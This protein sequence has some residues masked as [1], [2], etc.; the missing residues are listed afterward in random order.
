MRSKTI[1]I[2][3]DDPVFT[4]ILSYRLEKYQFCC[5]S[6]HTATDALV[7]LAHQS[8]PDIVLLDYS[9]GPNEQSGVDLCRQIKYMMPGVPLV[10]LTGNDTTQT[11]VSCLDAGADQYVLKPYVLEELLARIRAVGRVYE[12][13]DDIGRGGDYEDFKLNIFEQT[14]TTP[15]GTARLTEKEM[16]FAE[17]MLKSL[18]SPLSREYLYSVIYEREFDSL[19]R[20][21]DMLAVRFRKKL[22]GITKH[23]SIK[24]VRGEGYIMYCRPP[25]T[26]NNSLDSHD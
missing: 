3:D 22:S 16:A 21:L 8:P 19:S 10:M 23:Y 14:L 6:Y 11:I 9:L 12:K 2:V 18:G 15:E 26:E 20:N 25:N 24:S 17:L 5:E 4:R 13:K 1:V 7:K